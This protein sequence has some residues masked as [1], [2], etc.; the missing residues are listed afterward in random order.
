MSSLPLPAPTQPVLSQP[1]Q[2][3]WQAQLKLG[4]AQR[5]GRS[6]LAERRHL[7][8]LRVQKPLYP[9]GDA[10]CHAIIV[11]PQAASPAA[12]PWISKWMSE[13]PATL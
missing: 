6:F 9:E 4:F 8:P 12:I 2:A 3:S 5:A 11:H 7:G 10:I 1:S 13:A